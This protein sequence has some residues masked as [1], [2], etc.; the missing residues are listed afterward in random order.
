MALIASSVATPAF[1]AATRPTDLWS[2]GPLP[3]QSAVPGVNQALPARAA[4]PDRLTNSKAQAVGWPAA[5]SVKVTVGSGGGAAPR[6][7]SVAGKAAPA[8]V[9]V[10]GT[11]LKIGPSGSLTAGLLPAKTGQK[12]ALAAPAAATPASVQVAMLDRARG[13]Q[14]GVRGPVFTVTPSDSS[15]GRVSLELDYSAFKDAYGANWGSRLQLVQLPACALTTPDQAQCR[16]TTPVASSANDAVGKRL[17]ADVDLPTAAAPTSGGAAVQSRAVAAASTPGPLVLAATAPSGATSAGSGSGSFAVTSLSPSSKWAVNNSG[18]F[19]WSYDIKVPPA[20]GGA[21]PSVVLSYNSATVDGRTSATSPQ[22]SQVGDG[23]ELAAGGYIE[24]SFRSCDQDGQKGDYDQCFVG[25]PDEHLSVSLG[26]HS[27][28]VIKDSGSGALHLANDDGSKIE[29]LGGAPNGLEGGEYF[30]LTD[31][32][33]VQYYFGATHLPTGNGFTTADSSTQSAWGVP[34]YGNDP[35][36][37][38][39]DTTFANSRCGSNVGWRWNLDFVVDTHNNVTAFSY[40]PETNYYA[41]GPFHVLKQYVRSG[42]LQQITYGQ[43]VADYPGTPAA[44]VTFT[45]AE[46]CANTV[47]TDTTH[48]DTIDCSTATLSSATAAHWQDVPYDQNCDSSS[49]SNYGPSFWTTKRLSSIKTEVYDSAT[50]AY[51]PVDTYNLSHSYPDPHDTTSPALWLDQIQRTGTDTGGGGP[52]APPL[53]PVTFTSKQPKPNR[54]AGSISPSNV[55]PL[56]RYRLGGLTTESGE[57]ITVTYAQDNPCNRAALPAESNDDQLCYPV[58]W[59][60]TGY[61]APILDWFYKYPVTQVDESDQSGLQPTP[62]PKTTTFDYSQGKPAWLHNDNPFTPVNQRTWDRFGGFSKIITRVGPVGAPVTQSATEYFQGR[63]GDLTG[64]QSRPIRKLTN[65]FGEQITDDPAVAGMVFQTTTYTGAGG[66]PVSQTVNTPWVSSPTAT[67]AV[68]TE[69]PALPNPTARFTGTSVARTRSLLH[70]GGWRITET[71]TAYDPATGL[72]TTVDDKGEV[73]G[74]GNPVAN[75]LTPRSCT[76]T[77]YATAASNRHMLSYRAE[78]LTLAGGC[79]TAAS[80]AT[81]LTDSKFSYGSPTPQTIDP[82]NAGDV[83]ASQSVREFDGA[84]N[85]VW[86]KP[87]VTTYDQYGRTRSV[88][89]ALGAL[90]Q[91]DYTPATKALPYQVE[92]TNPMGWKTDT[93]LDVARALPLSTVDANKRTVSMTYDSLGRISAGWA[94]THPKASNAGTP[95]ARFTYV[96]STNQPSTVKTETLQLDQTYAV[97]FKIYDSMMRIFQDQATPSDGTAGARIVSDTAYDSVGHAYKVSA[98]Y[99]DGTGV[100]GSGVFS[101]ADKTTPAATLVTYDGMGREITSTRYG[102]GTAQAVTTT[103]YRG[104]D[105]VDRTPPSGSYPTTT[106]LDARGKTAELWQWHTPTLPGTITDGDS[107]SVDKTS[108]RYDALG[109]SVSQTDSVGRHGTGGTSNSW[110]TSYNQQGKVTVSTDPDTGTSQS[111]YDDNGQ[112]VTSKDSRG[113]VVWHGY[114]ALGRPTQQRLDSATGNLLATWA[115]D[116][117]PDGTSNVRGQLASSAKYPGT[118][119]DT[120]QFTSQTVVGGYSTGYQPTTT[121]VNVV[122]TSSMQA[123]SYTTTNHYL[124]ITETLDSTDYPATGALSAETVKYTYSASGLPM[125]M[126]G[127]SRMVSWVDY[128]HLGQPMRTTM[129][130]VP[131]QLV[132]TNNWDPSTGRLLEAVM[133]KEDD[134]TAFSEDATYAYDLSGRITGV[135]NVQ[136]TTGVDTQCYA[137]DYL[138]RLTDAWS[139]TGGVQIAASPSVGNTGQCVNSNPP[140][141]GSAAGRIGGTAPYWQSYSY[142]ELGNRLTKTDHDVTGAAAKDVTTTET[143][144]PSGTPGTSPHQVRTAK[145]GSGPTSTYSY[146][147]TGQPTT[148]AGSNGANTKLTW[149]ATGKVSS[150]TTTPPTSGAVTSGGSTCLDGTAANANSGQQIILALCDPSS[151]GQQWSYQ[152]GTL[153]ALGKCAAVIGTGTM[154][155]VRLANCDG[156]AG[157]FWQ[158]RPDGSLYNPGTGLC[159]DSTDG[160]GPGAPL[161]V[162]RC[163]N[164]FNQ[165]WALGG[166]ATVMLTSPSNTCWDGTSASTDPNQQVVLANCDPSVAGQ[167][168]SY[169]GTS[170]QLGGKCATISGAQAALSPVRLAAC[171]GSASQVWQPRAD[172]TLFNPGTGLCADSTNGSGVGAPL[173]IWRCN[174]AYNQRWNASG[175]HA[176]SYT[177]DAAGNQLT[178]TD[179]QTTTLYLG[180]DQLTFAADR[181]IKS[182]TRYYTMGSAPTTVRV[183]PTGGTETLSYQYTD[184]HGTA[185]D[186]VDANTRALTRRMTTPFGESRGTQ[187]VLGAWPSDHGFVNGTQDDTTGLT[188]LGAREYSPALG[189]F[190]SSDPVLDAASPQQWNGYAYSNNNPVNQSDPSGL[191]PRDECG[192]YGQNPG[193]AIGTHGTESDVSR[194]Q[195]GDRGLDCETL[196]HILGITS[197]DDEQFL[198]LMSKMYSDTDPKEMEKRKKKAEAEEARKAQER[199]RNDILGNALEGLDILRASV[200]RVTSTTGYCVSGG[201]MVTV[202]VGGSVCFVSVKRPDGKVDFGLTASPGI[203]VG[204]DGAAVAV[205]RVAGNADGFDQLAGKGASLSFAGGDGLGVYGQY[206]Q[207]IGTANSRGD[208]VGSATAGFGLGLGVGAGIGFDNTITKR[209]FTLG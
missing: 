84:G 202:G 55:L 161:A 91:T 35:G 137:Y 188:N 90:T 46:R 49:C 156:S 73:D 80:A 116:T 144:S 170:F 13:E 68:P 139:D 150:L 119:T 133:A 40:Q 187:P 4:S 134:T 56:N 67:G 200:K 152:S 16:T 83:T 74:S 196:C 52:G 53:P 22:A 171:D 151:A 26:S 9:K 168:W 94:A 190:I 186:T 12:S 28:D 14:A 11:A 125:T 126:F 65:A 117:V 86:T 104:T 174:T 7:S 141:A 183:S 154:S 6:T 98:P 85:A 17:V 27:G 178:R 136:G 93:V 131:N 82:A 160:T 87:T 165:H 95:S 204:G 38:C 110:T 124:P 100:P 107:G 76:S 149:D 43:Q 182:A 120:T 163:N 173:A 195:R 29:L 36:E 77:T 201:A 185:T 64:D 88:T 57:S 180:A 194:P 31:Q 111:S 50:S 109:R 122:A 207:A 45:S 130:A 25:K 23:W 19:T 62:A 189:R 206:E 101:P 97:D 81:V 128:T 102:L 103:A 63:S 172:G 96:V 32:K 135:R 205:G 158:S 192:G 15:G 167:Q 48:T 44:R 42:S 1:A 37:P 179:D 113:Q 121:T 79:G 39:N 129:G 146:D 143:Y 8:A 147:Q 5:A 2:P 70:T 30:R 177:Y 176:T 71:D 89:D 75:T 59:T 153:R 66:S 155:P 181:S 47:N 198:N 169:Q 197:P 148:I 58:R 208:S 191:C 92:I 142:D 24:R 184:P 115:Y 20:V 34:V 127:K 112:L 33:G 10:P 166:V 175:I 18:S 203:Q 60:P 69:T 99:F 118:G 140:A 3:A 159:A 145:S 164:A 105:A 209:L 72:T 21:A 162:W 78:V 193:M 123:V 108:Y 51:R 41:V 114:D 138:G 199:A 106:L 157:Q 132:V 61:D 54:V